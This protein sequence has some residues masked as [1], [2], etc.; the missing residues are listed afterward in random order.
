MDEWLGES[1]S[2]SSSK[3]QTTLDTRLKAS[4]NPLLNHFQS[5]KHSVETTSPEYTKMPHYTNGKWEAQSIN[6]QKFSR[7]RANFAAKVTNKEPSVSKSKLSRVYIKY[8]FINYKG[9][10]TTKNSNKNNNKSLSSSI[11]SVSYNPADNQ[12][13]FTIRVKCL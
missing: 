6:K 8:T 7:T 4:A 13:N 11:N 10:R 12:G 5:L 9:S 3:I 1:N 2:E